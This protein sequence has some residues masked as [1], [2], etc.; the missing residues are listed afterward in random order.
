MP[1]N[2]VVDTELGCTAIESLSPENSAES[3]VVLLPYLTDNLVHCPA[4]QLVVREDLEWKAVLYLVLLD[5]LTIL[6]DRSTE[7]LHKRT[8][9]ESSR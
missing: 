4:V 2:N 8:S 3:T 1:R 9:S 6:V 7:Y 5:G